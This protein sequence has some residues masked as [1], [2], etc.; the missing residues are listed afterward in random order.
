MT[1]P[2]DES[3]EVAIARA[4][5]IATPIFAEHGWKWARSNGVPSEAEIAL[6][7]ARMIRQ[8]GDERGEWIESGRFKV[9]RDEDGDILIL[10]DL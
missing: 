6:G 7:L 9:E 4:A 2:E 5:K 10:L 3:V 1:A 8:L